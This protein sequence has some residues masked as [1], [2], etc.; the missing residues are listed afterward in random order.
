M[1]PHSSVL[2]WRIPGTAETGGLLW[3]PTESDTTE[4]TQLTTLLQLFISSRSFLVES[5]F[6]LD[7][8][9]C[10]LHTKTVL[11]LRDILLTFYFIFFSL[12]H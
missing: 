1:A 12:L 6:F 8:Q 9:S 3:G 4:V 7:R 10:Y 5:L 11:F 2:A